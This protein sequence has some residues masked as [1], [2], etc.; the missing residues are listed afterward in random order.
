MTS[1]IWMGQS[2]Y[3]GVGLGVTSKMKITIS[4]NLGKIL[5]R[6][7]IFLFLSRAALAEPAMWV[8]HD[9][10]STIYLVGTVHLL[11]HET[12]WN[13]AKIKKALA[14]SNELWLEMVDGDD[15]AKIQA[16]LVHYG[17][18]RNK[19]LSDKL[20]FAEKARLSKVAADY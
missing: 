17:V 10:D 9:S 19:R 7:G 3:A 4:S 1:G 16:L 5:G 13:S 12:E 2:S 20:N 18:D 14:D 15:P 6:L 11:R 8:I